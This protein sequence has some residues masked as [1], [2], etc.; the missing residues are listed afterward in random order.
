MEKPLTPR[1]QLLRMLA[2]RVG[3]FLGEATHPAL[4]MLDAVGREAAILARMNDPQGVYAWC[5]T[6][7]VQ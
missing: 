4:R 6:C 1:E 7:Q 3:D 5:L 2:T